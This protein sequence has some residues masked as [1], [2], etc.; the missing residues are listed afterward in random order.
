MLPTYKE[1]KQQNKNPKWSLD[2]VII[3]GKTSAIV[4]DK[5]KDININTT[6]KAVALQH[7]IH[8]TPPEH[9]Q[10]SSFQGHRV[11]ITNQDEIVPALHALYSDAR[12]ARATHNIYAYRL[13]T[14]S[15]HLEHYEDDGEWGA[16]SKLLDLLKANH[17]EDTLVCV[18]RWYGGTHLGK[19]RF[20]FILNCAKKSLQI[21]T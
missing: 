11:H 5:V 6:E 7:D 17:I 9:L 3:N 4:K 10:G 15:G 20:D 13:K 18:T 21:D 12:I 1:A 16:G 19:A 8:H 2:K 14:P